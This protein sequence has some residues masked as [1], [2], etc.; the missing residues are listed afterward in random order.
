MDGSPV[1]TEGS[2][3]HRKSGYKSWKKKYRKMRIL[4]DQK[5]QEGEDLHKQEDRASATVK[6]LAV[7]ND[8]LLDLILDINNSPQIP[9]DKRID[10]S[11]RPS[12]GSK[13]VHPIDGK[14]APPQKEL[15]MKKL[16]MLLEEIPHS[17]YTSAKDAK[18]SYLSDLAAPE[19]EPFPSS[20][21]SADDIDN[22]IH[23]ID[24]SIDPETHIPTLAPRAHPSTNPIQHAHLKNPTSVTNWLRKHAPKIFLQDGEAHDGDD[25]AQAGHHAGGRKTRGSRGERGGGRGRGKRASLATRTVD[26]E[27]DWDASMDDDAELSTPVGRGKRKRDDDPGYRPGGSG[28]RP[29]KKKRK[30]DVDGTPAVRKSKKDS[31]KRDD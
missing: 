19:G 24:S 12:P 11:L 20:F 7:E 1:K 2:A 23:D 30:S 5:M 8:R 27:R 26:R 28:G 18:R 25:E 6:R 13:K 21:L 22:Y 14:H 4:F 17:S 16:Q 10:V 3:D 31:A 29:V 9:L 15:A